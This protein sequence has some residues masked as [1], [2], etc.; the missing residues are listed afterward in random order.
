MEHED[1]VSFE[2]A[3]KLKSLGF[4]WK[5]YT[6]YHWDNW[7]GLTRSGMY[8]NH[9]MFQKGIS[10]PTLAQAQKWLREKYQ[11]QCNAD[12]NDEDKKWYWWVYPFS[13]DASNMEISD[14]ITYPTY[15]EALSNAIDKAIEF[16]KN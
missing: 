5:C 9:N 3:F 1:Y 13:K 8:E 12:Y 14:D 2:Q 7:C 4:N 11:I 16:I 6:W 10:A 15:E